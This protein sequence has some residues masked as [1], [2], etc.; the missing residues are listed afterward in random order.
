MSREIRTAIVAFTV[1]KSEHLPLKNGEQM[2]AD[3]VAEEVIDVVQQALDAWY[4]K[5]GNL[6]LACEP[7]IG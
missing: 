1:H 7:D 5:R 4:A 2:Y 6:L 3:D